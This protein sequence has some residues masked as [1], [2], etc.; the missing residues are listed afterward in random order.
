MNPRSR[1]I[2]SLFRCVPP[3]LAFAA[4]CALLFAALGCEEKKAASGPPKMPPAPVLLGV[5]TLQDTPLTIETVGH[6]ETPLAVQIKSMVAGQIKE[7]RFREGAFVK[8]GD[9]LFII[10]KA[11][12]EAAL[13]QYEANLA[14]DTASLN[15]ARKDLIR[16]TALDKSQVVS[17]SDYE[18]AQ[19]SASTLE[20]AIAYDQAAITKAKLDLEYCTIKAPFTGRVGV[21]QLDLGSVIKA[22]DAA[23]VE[24]VQIEP[25]NVRFTVPERRFPEV[26]KQLAAGAIEVWADLD[27]DDAGPTKG[28]LDF[29]DNKVD[30]ETGVIALKAVY[31]N[32]DHLFWPGQFLNVSLVLKVEK[33][34]VVAP[35]RAIQTGPQGKY[36][37]VVKPDNTAELRPVVVERQYKD[38]TVVAKGLAAGERIV[39]DGH[40][41]VI[42]GGPL[43]DR[44]APAQPAGQ[45]PSGQPAPAQ[46][47]PAKS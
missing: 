19:T 17:R 4:C 10:D 11:P 34:R 29:I 43:M 25:I 23:L 24:I 36:V 12:F 31:P 16:Y 14:K 44:S 41:R 5:S 15:K 20:A 1:F 26:R 13:A 46:Q 47:T 40:L 38:Q 6:V 33:D 21:I 9:V 30:K 28:A 32:K 8:A 22:N 27:G 2:V 45:Q 37:Y 7:V 18:N 3:L 39:I 35:S 42:P